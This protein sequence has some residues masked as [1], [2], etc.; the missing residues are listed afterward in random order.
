[1]STIP[2][3]QR[4]AHL[5]LTNHAVVRM[6]QRG[7]PADAIDAA[8]TYG[9]SVHAKDATFYVVGRKEIQRYASRGIDLSAMSG[10]QVLVGS[11]G[12]VITAYRNQDLHAIRSKRRPRARSAN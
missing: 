8:L 4:A 6:Q 10:L 9:R 5:K 2:T 7:I 12:A 1:M 3:A 11:D